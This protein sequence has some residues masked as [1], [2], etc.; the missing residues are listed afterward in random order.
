[1]K[2]DFKKLIATYSAKH[3]QFSVVTVPTLQFLMIDG[4]GDPNTA[5]SYKDAL[6]TLYPVAYKLKFF[7]KAELG[8]DYGVMPLEALWWSDDMESF[9][10]ARDKSRWDWTLLNMVPDWITQEHMEMVRQVVAK[11]GEAPALESLRLEPLEEGL[12]VQT[13]HIGPYDHEGPVLEEMHNNFIPEQSLS[14]TGRHHEIY[15]GDPRRTAPEKLK[16]ILRQPVSQ[17]TK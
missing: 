16:T 14:M 3:G 8:Q 1:M 10:S 12:S 6:T 13:L 15:L 9:T 2:S 4:H 17:N 5:Q 11:K 7:S